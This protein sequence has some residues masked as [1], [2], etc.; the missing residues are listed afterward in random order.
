MAVFTHC[1]VCD[2]VN[3]G[4]LTYS[5]CVGR[6]SS[7]DMWVYKDMAISYNQGWLH[8]VGVL[9]VTTSSFEGLQNHI[10]I[11]DNMCMHNRVSISA[12][13]WTWISTF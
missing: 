4:C 1:H 12:F 6:L 10:K 11:E 7:W 13:T 8:G 9:L 3:K 5:K 2:L